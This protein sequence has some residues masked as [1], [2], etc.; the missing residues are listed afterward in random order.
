MPRDLPLDGAAVTATFLRA[1]NLAD[2]PEALSRFADGWLGYMNRQ[3]RASQDIALVEPKAATSSP[4]GGSLPGVGPG[5][6]PP[7]GG[8]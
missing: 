7:G 8:N 1:F 6:G 4:G 3:S 2:T 5:G